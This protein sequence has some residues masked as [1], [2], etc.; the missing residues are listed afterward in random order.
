MR[1]TFIFNVRLTASLLEFW[2]CV[3]LRTKAHKATSKNVMS[4]AVLLCYFG[5]CFKFDGE[6]IA[7]CIDTFNARVTSCHAPG[8]SSSLIN[9]VADECR[10]PRGS[11]A[12]PFYVP[13]AVGLG[14][15]ILTLIIDCFGHL[16]H[17]RARRSGNR[18]NY[19]RLRF[20]NVGT[21]R[22]SLPAP[23]RCISGL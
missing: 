19:A 2:F 18:D 9:C 10:A 15:I 23:C 20:T 7:T 11:N 14:I 17:T 16:C 22:C 13:L 4:W 3:L 5:R 12:M 6:Q 21:A 8:N 1:R